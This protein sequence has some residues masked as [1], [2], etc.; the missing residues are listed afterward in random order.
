MA[1]TEIRYP[2]IDVQLSGTDGNAFAIM[3]AVTRAMR[4]KGV[5]SSEIDKFRAECMAGD[6]DNLLRTCMAWVDV[7]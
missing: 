4:R 6:Y 1:A 5:R 7:S 2:D 3:G